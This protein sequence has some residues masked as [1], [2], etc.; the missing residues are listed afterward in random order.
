MGEDEMR[1]IAAVIAT[2][3]GDAFEAERESLS[4][5]TAALMDRHPLYPHLTAALA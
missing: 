4:A 5:R 1:E 3:L 2:A